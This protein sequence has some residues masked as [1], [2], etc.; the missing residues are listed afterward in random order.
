MSLLERRRIVGAWGMC[1]LAPW[2]LSFCGCC[3]KIVF[4]ALSRNAQRKLCDPHVKHG[5]LGILDTSRYETKRP[6]DAGPLGIFEGRPRDGTR[7]TLIIKHTIRMSYPVP[8]RSQIDK[9]A[10]G[11]LAKK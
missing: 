5:A 8:G 1:L 10:F 11:I 6:L 4:V 2:T 7:L 3:R 9:A